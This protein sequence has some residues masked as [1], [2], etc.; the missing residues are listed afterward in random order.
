M[1]DVSTLPRDSK[2]LSIFPK[3]PGFSQSFQKELGGTYAFLEYSASYWI[4]HVQEARDDDINWIHQTLK[5]CDLGYGSRHWYEVYSDFTGRYKYLPRNYQPKEI[6]AIGF[7]LVN[8]LKALQESE[9]DHNRL[10]S[11]APNLLGQAAENSGSD[12]DY[13]N[14]RTHNYTMQS[15]QA[16]FDRPFYWH[17]FD[18]PIGVLKVLSKQPTAQEVMQIVLDSQPPEFLIKSIKAAASDGKGDIAVMQLLLQQEGANALITEEIMKA[19]VESK[20]VGMMQLLLR[21]QGAGALITEKIVK[22]VAEIKSVELMQL[23]LQQQG[24][25]VLITKEVMKT[26]VES[27]SVELMQLLLSQQEA[28]LLITKDI[29]K[30]TAESKSVEVMRLLLRQ[31]G[32]DVLVTEEVLKAATTDLSNSN[33]Q[34]MMLLLLDQPGAS[35]LI[36]QVV[37][38]K[39]SGL[40]YS[41]RVTLLKSIL[42]KITITEK[43][44]AT[45]VRLFNRESVELLLDQRGA[46]VLV[47]ADVMKAALENENSSKELTLLLFDRY[48]REAY[49][50]LLLLGIRRS[51]PFGR[52]GHLFR[53]KSSAGWVYFPLKEAASDQPH[54]RDVNEVDK[55]LM[56]LNSSQ[57][58]LS[59]FSSR[60]YL[61][62]IQQIYPSIRMGLSMLPWIETAIPPGHQRLYWRN[63]STFLILPFRSF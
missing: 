9:L 29:M 8:V 38:E 31:P 53:V 21:Q 57:S 47:T 15:L 7:G 14:R 2:L 32:A 61:P 16:V 24:V 40:R 58:I 50:A 36:T 35:A 10:A 60:V 25:D 41:D 54:V 18:I 1:P 23:L 33:C 43:M 49:E 27:K 11:S 12:E 46:Y 13:L 19:V 34:E 45:F 17:A 62:S 63:V 28:K 6:W 4:H 52:K 26:V 22:A 3:I 44:T 5:L 55:G 20:N 56:M 37:W 39:V 42:G 59:R 30:A 48:E 51:V